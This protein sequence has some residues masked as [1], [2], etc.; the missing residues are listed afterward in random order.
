MRSIG[1]ERS[2][3]SRLAQGAAR[4]IIVA[5]DADGD[6]VPVRLDHLHLGRVDHVQVA[7]EFR[8][9]ARA[10]PPGTRGRCARAGRA[11]PRAA[12]AGRPRRAASVARPH[13]G[14]RLAE[15]FLIEGLQQIID[16][17][18][19]ERLECIGVVGGDEHQRGQLLGLQ[20][21]REID[22]VQRVHLDVEKQQLRPQA[23]IASSAGLAVAVLADHPRSPSA[24]QIR[25]ACAGRPARHRR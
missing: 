20:R 5:A 21:A 13:A 9:Q 2:A 19:L 25:A 14:Q 15:A 23:R 6:I 17:A 11:G 3:S 7:V 18:H 4:V 10:V 8:Q 16:G 24:S 1:C 12:L 22:A